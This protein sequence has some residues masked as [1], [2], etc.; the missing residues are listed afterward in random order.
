MALPSCSKS[1]YGEA[2][3]WRVG[4]G[5]FL[6]FSKFCFSSFC[7]V[8]HLVPTSCR[9]KTGTYHS[10]SRCRSDELWLMATVVSSHTLFFAPPIKGWKIC[11]LFSFFKQGILGIRTV[12][13]FKLDWVDGRSIACLEW[14]CQGVLHGSP[15]ENRQLSSCGIR[16]TTILDVDALIHIQALYKLAEPLSVKTHPIIFL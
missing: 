3:D 7:L 13:G 1:G 14:V 12:H 11:V 4:R 9:L 5:T 10:Q 16:V 6:S 2:C 8:L 15:W